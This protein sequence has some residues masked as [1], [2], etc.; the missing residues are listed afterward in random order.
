MSDL[1]AILRWYAV[2]TLISVGL[3]PPIVW[4]GRGPGPLAYGIVRP[5]ALVVLTWLVWWPAALF[6]LP[7]SRPVLAVALLLAAVGGWY[8]W[9]RAGFS[10]LNRRAW[11]G[12]EL[13]WVVAFLGYAWFRSYN[14]DIINTE[15]P[16]EIALLSSVSRSTEVPAPD[17][18]FAGSAIN[19][20]YLGYQSMATIIKLSGV[21]AAIAFN[22]GLAT[23]FASCATAAAT[24]GGQLARRFGLR[25]RWIIAAALIA[26]VMLLLAGNLETPKSLLEDRQAT[27][28]AGW[29]D[30]VGWNASRVIVDNGVNQVGDAKDTINEFPAFSFVLGDLHPHVLAYPLLAGVIGL[31]LG[32]RRGERR[33]DRVRLAVLGGLVGL[34]YATNSWDAPAGFIVVV[35]MLALAWGGAW[36]RLAL[37]VA[38]VVAGAVIGALPFL[39]QFDAPVGVTAS[40]VPAWIADLPV[41]GSIVSTFG[42]VSWRPSSVSELLTV[43]GLWIAV[44]AAFAIVELVG[45]TRYRDALARRRHLVSAGGALLFAIGFAWAPAVLLVGLPLIVAAWIALRSPDAGKR[46]LAALF[47][48]GFGLTLVPEFVYIQDPFADRMNTVFKLYFQAWLVLSVASAAAIVGLLARANGRL[49]STIAIVGTIGIVA[50]LTYTPLSASDWTND[51]A[52]RRGLNGEAYLAL[53]NADEFAAIEWLRANANDGDTIV[54]SPGCSYDLVDGIP[55]NRMSAFT[56]LPTTIGWSFHEYQWRRGELD[57]ISAVLDERI[58]SANATL[59]GAAPSLHDPR[60]LILGEQETLAE[61]SCP[62]VVARDASAAGALEQADWVEAFSQGSTR[63]FVRLDDVL[64]LR[65]R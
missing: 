58:R 63:V 49:R 60:F 5:V 3:A 64:A 10:G 24:I 42:V 9:Y 53:A 40:G 36:R 23:L 12:F 18:W 44:F 43:H 37:D 56:G 61:S 16:M 26:P 15:K 62:N 55:M 13:L 34:L 6:G 50:S 45:D 27:V 54:E 57:A 8:L 21:P 29:W 41:V 28:D 20:Y 51:F 25:P 33:E 30:G 2:L 35:T 4:L 1:D 31:A 65:L 32:L 19:Y 52:E 39:V 7:F 46:I 47:A 11:L 59:D 17:P 38:T 22:L 48:I 14:P